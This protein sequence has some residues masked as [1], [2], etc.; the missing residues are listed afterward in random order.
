MKI[1]ETIITIVKIAM[2]SFSDFDY[3]YSYPSPDD[4]QIILEGKL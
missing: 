1:N 3:T 4:S 2:T